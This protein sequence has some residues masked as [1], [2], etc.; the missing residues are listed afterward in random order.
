MNYLAIFKN[1]A[2]KPH[3][4]LTSI[5]FGILYTIVIL[6]LPNYR[7]FLNTFTARLP[8]PEKIS[9]LSLLAAG[10]FS[11]LPPL[12]KIL[13]FLTALLLGINL[14]LLIKRLRKMQENKGAKL[15][16]GTGSFFSI[17]SSGCASCGV[18]IFSFFGIGT[19]FLPFGNIFLSVFAIFLLLFSIAYILK[20]MAKEAACQIPG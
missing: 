1:E 11:I 14:T 4:F 17:A 19:G 15:L 12:E 3:F 10:S 9:F 5:V 2:K 16:V 6:L 7:L 8:L 13:F 18:S 20:S